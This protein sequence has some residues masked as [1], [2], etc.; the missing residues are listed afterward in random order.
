MPWLTR[1]VD[2]LL[3][4]RLGVHP[5][6]VNMEFVVEKVIMGQ[7]LLRILRLSPMLYTQRSATDAI[8]FQQSDKTVR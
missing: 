1:L 6:H 4:W 2:G 7:V 3:S 5:T 8:H